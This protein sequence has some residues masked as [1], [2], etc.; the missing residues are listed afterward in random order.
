MAGINAVS[1]YLLTLL[2]PR[3][4]DRYRAHVSERDGYAKEL[5]IEA[6]STVKNKKQ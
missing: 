5:L 2:T 4:L 3:C 1:E 6:A